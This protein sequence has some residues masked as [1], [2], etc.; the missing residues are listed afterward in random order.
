[1]DLCL[2][3][4]R[5]SEYELVQPD[6]FTF[7]GHCSYPPDKQFI[8]YD[9]YPDAD[10]YRKLMLYDIRTRKGLLLADLF[11]GKDDRLPS[12][13]IR[14]DLHPR[15]NRDGSAISFDSTHEGHRHVYTMDMKD[16]L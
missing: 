3:T 9:S 11:S 15:W 12:G 1:M 5:A 14:C 8:L 2:V 16:I 6:Y 7:D 13:D 10:G 4:D